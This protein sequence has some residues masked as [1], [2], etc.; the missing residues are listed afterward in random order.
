MALWLQSWV[1]GQA[2]HCA[3]EKPSFALLGLGLATLLLS[4][5]PLHQEEAPWK[6]CSLLSIAKPWHTFG[7]W[8][9]A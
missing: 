5:L 4:P 8:T 1:H 9:D 3:S 6:Q 2:E 7:R